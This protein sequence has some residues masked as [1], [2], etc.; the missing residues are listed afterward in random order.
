MEIIQL[1]GYTEFEKMNIA[2][3][4]LVPRQTKECGLE[5]VPLDDHRERDP[6][7][8][9]PLHAGEPACARSSARSPASAAR[10]RARSS[11]PR[12]RSKPIEVVAQ[13]RPEVPR[14]AEVPP[15][16]EGRARRDR[17]H[18]RPLRDELRRRRAPRVRGRGRARQGQARDHRPAREGHGGE[19]A[20][21]DELRALARGDRSGSSRSSTRRSTST[22]TSRSSSART[23]RARASRWR[24]RSRARS[25]R[26]P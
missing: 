7:R 14:R 15:R 23:D 2:V 3:K 8:H 4:Y 17:P 25:S 20:G 19:R 5:D 22:F 6:H 26:C 16:Q 1:S 12:A 24:R 18:E 11:K 13:E 10:S 9:P 21:R